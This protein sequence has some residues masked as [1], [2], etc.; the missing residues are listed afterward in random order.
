M[1]GFLGPAG[2]E[3]MRNWVVILIGLALV[4]AACGGSEDASPVAAADEPSSEDS[5]DGAAAEESSEA[6]DD[7][8]LGVSEESATG[9]DA[10]PIDT[11]SFEADIE[12]VEIVI[13]QIE[14][15]PL[16]DVPSALSDMR[17][18]A[19][20][21][22]LIDVD[23]ILSGGPPPDGI[24][25]VDSPR[26]QT[27]ESVDWLRCTEPVLSLQVGDEARA[28]PIQIMTWHELVNDTFGDV[29]VAVSYCPLCNSALA[30]RRDV[31]DRI[32]SFGTSGRLFNSSLVMY[33]RQ[34]QS[35]WTHF[36][37]T[38]VVGELTGQ[39]LELLPMQT[40]SWAN[41]KAAHP[42]GL[43]L[44]RDT[45]FSR[46]YGRNPYV[47]YDQVGNSPFL[48]DGEADPRLDAKERVVAI[49]GED[50]SIVVVL[51][52]LSELGVID[53]TLDGSPATVWHVPGT[54]TALEAE[55]VFDGR[56]V[57]AVGVFSPI[58][59]GEELTF[60]R[61]GDTF[62]DG[63]GST[64]NIL[65]QAIDGPLGGQQLTAIEHLDTFWFAIAAFQPDSVIVTS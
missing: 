45:G 60:T 9:A 51:S 52:N 48:F 22:P 27:A 23:R 36:N 41:F 10:V 20:P 33:D 15:G 43:V 35:L 16:E 64:F 6:P 40:T 18:P 2:S 54:S 61:D 5:S 57:G 53:L 46:N 34:T 44:T 55:S 3:T 7:G 59:G 17:D 32:H 26:F 29:P 1:E 62:S 31:G 4:A 50:E 38:A 12:P 19:F 30:Y 21:A 24:P 37:G 13:D 8:A 65:G 28:Y 14:D 58:L 25:P 56:D 47:G 39:E 11:C 49:R 42:D 63:A